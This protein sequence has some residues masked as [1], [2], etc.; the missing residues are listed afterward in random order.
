MNCVEALNE[1]VI[2]EFKIFL[3][4]RN[5]NIEKYSSSS[6]PARDSSR[7]FS[8]HEAEHHKIRYFIPKQEKL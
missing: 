5:G 3:V 8:E 2:A 4:T 1:V 7:K 6:G